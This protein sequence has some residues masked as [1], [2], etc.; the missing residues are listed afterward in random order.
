MSENPTENGIIVVLKSAILVS[1]SSLYQLVDV[2][3][4]GLGKLNRQIV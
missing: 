4:M 1:I 2:H 3:D